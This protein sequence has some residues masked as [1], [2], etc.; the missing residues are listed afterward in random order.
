MGYLKRKFSGVP[1]YRMARWVAV[2]L[3]I[4]LL[5]RGA[6]VAV[7]PHGDSRSLELL[8]WLTQDAARILVAIALLVLWRWPRQWPSHAS[9]ARVSDLSGSEPEG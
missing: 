9:N 5:Y 2:F 1:P 8:E 6:S 7:S 4:T 3:A